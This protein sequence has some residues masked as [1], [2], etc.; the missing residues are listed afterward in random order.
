MALI[1][2]PA[3][4]LLSVVGLDLSLNGSAACHLVGDPRS[5]DPPAIVTKR[6]PWK[7]PVS[8]EANRVDRLIHV[9]EAIA[10][11]VA[12]AA[13]HAI[14]VEDFAYAR[15]QGAARIGEMTGVVKVALRRA[16]GLTVIPIP[17]SEARKRII[18]DVRGRGEDLKERILEALRSRGLDFASHDEADA[19]VIARTLWQD[20]CE[21][22]AAPAA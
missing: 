15:P 16:T 9:S 12:S 6:F 8:E 10:A 2:P 7:G 5:S 4:G 1:P 14:A 22:L 20:F 11:F 3:P 18:P 17:A 13:P 19:Y 21:A